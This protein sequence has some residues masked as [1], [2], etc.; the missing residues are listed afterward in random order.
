MT[1]TELYNKLK[2]LISE[3]GKFD[4]NADGVLDTLIDNDIFDS[5]ITS[6]TTT[7]NLNHSLN[8]YINDGSSTMI[9]SLAYDHTLN[10][11]DI[12]S[13]SGIT[14]T[15]R[16]MYLK[17]VELMNIFNAID[18][19]LIEEPSLNVF[20]S[21]YL[22]GKF[23]NTSPYS[24]IK[25]MLIA[26]DTNY[27]TEKY[28]HRPKFI[29]IKFLKY[30]YTICYYKLTYDIIRDYY[31]KL[32]S[33]D[34]ST[35][36]LIDLQSDI[37]T[38]NGY[39]T[40]SIDS[41]DYNLSSITT[42]S[43]PI[44]NDLNAYNYNLLSM[45]TLITSIDEAIQDISNDSIQ[46]GTK[47]DESGGTTAV[48]KKVKDC[49]VSLITNKI[50]GIHLSDTA[51]KNA[52]IVS[53]SIK[54]ASTVNRDIDVDIKLA[55]DIN[56]TDATFSF[57]GTNK[58]TF[59]NYV[60]L[61][62]M[63]TLLV[64]YKTCLEKINTN[65]SN[66]KTKEREIL[67]N[68]SSNRINVNINK[69]QENLYKYDFIKN[70]DKL[71]NLNKSIKKNKDGITEN[72]TRSKRISL[73]NTINDYLLYTT[74]SIVIVSLIILGLVIK[75]NKYEIYL[76]Y[77]V[78]ILALYYVV[79]MLVQYLY[80]TKEDFTSSVHQ[81]SFNNFDSNLVNYVNNVYNLL[82][83]ASADS[84]YFEYV[85]PSIQKELGKFKDI[86]LITN[87][88]NTSSKQQNNIMQHDTNY[89]KIICEMMVV[90][91][92]IGIITYMIAVRMPDEINFIGTCVIIVLIAVTSY[93]IYM[94]YQR[95]RT[96][97]KRRDWIK[98][99]FSKEI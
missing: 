93:F 32:K 28:L 24:N 43:R 35:G 10:I 17:T 96:T 36:K 34:S 16:D 4:T 21:S 79:F 62:A 76:G 68:V 9:S 66:I 99:S 49:N 15:N 81:N 3:Y 11:N 92:L 30:F 59:E 27:T 78:A 97:Y 31:N 91:L 52:Y 29:F 1:D 90:Y 14:F 48:N 33:G 37:G 77:L 84:I 44:L 95:T 94:L 47:S 22:S 72:Q 8:T 40:I 18:R 25:S 82:V 71:S 2:D 45:N 51:Q 64:E 57:D 67:N 46:I 60:R 50:A 89:K 63:K 61:K 41:T 83:H 26:F 88:K 69:I 56:T 73:N 75:D 53:R 85:N 23:T 58:S 39:G 86:N 12:S 5:F 42:I 20:D 38:I 74:I 98:P 6:S 13:A 70:K 55:Y 80:L 19:E 54:N 87:M 65:L 7:F